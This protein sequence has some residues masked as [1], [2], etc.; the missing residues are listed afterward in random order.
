MWAFTHPPRYGV[1]TNPTQGELFVN[2]KVD[3]SD[4]LIREAGQN[5]NDAR[6]PGTEKVELRL[7]LL[8]GE[9]APSAASIQPYIDGL[10]PHLA[11]SNVDMEGITFDKP[12]VLLVE[13]FGTTGLKGA[14]DEDDGDCFSLFWRNIG[15]S[16]KD[17]VRGGRWGLGKTVFANSSQIST[18]LGLT[19]RTG[20]NEPLL[21]GQASLRKHKIGNEVYQPH[22]LFCAS[23]PEEFEL[24]IKA[25]A[26]ISKFRSAFGITRSDEPGL[27]I[28]VLFPHP[29]ITEES[30]IKAAIQHFFFPILR[31]RMSIKVNSVELNN[32][33]LG[34]LASSM[35]STEI[36]G[37]GRVIQVAT[38]ICSFPDEAFHTIDNLPGGGTFPS[39]LFSAAVFTE[40]TLDDL[41]SKYKS[42]ALVG[43]K[44]PL[45]VRPKNADSQPTHLKLFLKHDPALIKG[46]DYY[47]R[48]GI[49]VIEHRSFG[50]AEKAIGLLIAEEQTISK[51]LGDAENPA[52]TAWNAKAQG[53]ESKYRDP[54][55]TVMFVR[56]SLKQFFEI[57]AKEEDTKDQN[58]LIDVFY[59][60]SE[61]GEPNKSTNKGGGDPPPPLNPFPPP[62]PPRIRIQPIDGG[63]SIKP[64]SG[65]KVEDLPL[66]VTV[67]AAY[68][69]RRGNPFRRYHPSDFEFGK[70]SIKIEA[71]EI[72]RPSVSWDRNTLSFQ[73]ADPSFIL[74]A[75]GFDP[76]RDL[77]ISTT[78][79]SEEES[80][81]DTT[82]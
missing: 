62:K 49:S 39:T 47:L 13:D 10:I 74:D 55:K 61:E 22:A 50:D 34:E 25:P 31:G 23:Q 35:Q 64:G 67:K 32:D 9:N 76:N 4:T 30:L 8:R 29:S 2:D 81:D 53:L 41:K 15:E 73:V 5:T 37:M 26:E 80:D 24:P 20:D 63:F 60:N 40:G 21:I 36:K 59:I 58:A 54:Q 14:I 1:N 42:G 69:V 82:I 18:W 75:T 66:T 72:T 51:F 7:T 52:H 78:I 11:A 28:A 65:L 70:A 68:E 33:S 19:I 6:C 44:L 27:S 3:R 17:G 79:S 56:R 45:I 48:D 12:S 77:K 71:D 43:L 38:D 46:Q 57:V 16:H